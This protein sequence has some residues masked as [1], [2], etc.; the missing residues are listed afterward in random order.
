MASGSSLA[1]DAPLLLEEYQRRVF[2]TKDGESNESHD[3]VSSEALTDRMNAMKACA[4]RPMVSVR[5]LID[6]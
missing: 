2:E 6:Q 3:E 5:V 4:H 1:R